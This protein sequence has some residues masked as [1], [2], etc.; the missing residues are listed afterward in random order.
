MLCLHF[1]TSL[2]LARFEV[3]DLR[4]YGLDLAAFSSAELSSQILTAINLVGLALQRHPT[5]Q[6]QTAASECFGTVS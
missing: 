1:S 6:A 5:C 2:H 4:A 3:P